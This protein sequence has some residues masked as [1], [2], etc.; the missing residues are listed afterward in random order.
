MIASHAFIQNLRRSHYE[1]GIE[2]RHEL[3][4]LAPAFD[5]PAKAI[6]TTPTGIKSVSC[7][8]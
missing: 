3:L 8:R 6:Y 5:E 1:L 2:A 4:R 7:A